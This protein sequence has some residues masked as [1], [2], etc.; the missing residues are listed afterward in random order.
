MPGPKNIALRRADGGEPIVLKRTEAQEL[1]L[2]TRANTRKNKQGAFAVSLRLKKLNSDALSR[3]STDDNTN[4][5]AAE[6]A[7]GKKYV[8]WDE[9]LAYFQESTDTLAN[10]IADAES[11]ATPDELSLPVPTPSTKPKSVVSKDRNSTPN[12]RRIRATNTT[13]GKG[14]LAPASMLPDGMMAEKEILAAQPQRLPKP[15]SSRMKKMPV[16]SSATDPVPSSLSREVQ[17]PTVEVA[18]T[19]SEPAKATKERKSRL[20]TP[21]RV[22]LP[23]PLSTVPVE[24]KEN[25]SR[26]FV[27]STPKKGIPMPTVVVPPVV[28][29]GLPR[30]RG[31][32]L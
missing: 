12:A 30:R 4:S 5:S 21:K 20:A 13:P 19:V 1:G 32:K 6:V 23:Q 9:T 7:T 22:K 11:L 3:L 25:Q 26:A 17:L 10:M 24:G 31:R 29:T 2:L 8:R 18:P 27:A 14:L 16:A 28:E 15:K